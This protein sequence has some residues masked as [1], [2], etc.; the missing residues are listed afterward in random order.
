MGAG[1]RYSFI[2][3]I[4]KEYCDK[5]GWR[6]LEIGAGGAVYK[7]MFM[8]YIGTD[9]AGNP[10]GERGD[11]VAYCD[12]QKIPFKGGS[13]D[14]AFVVAA[15]YQIP[16]ASDVLDEVRRVLRPGGFFLIFDYNEMTTK[17]LKR[18]ERGGENQNQVW[19]PNE[20]KRLATERGFKAVVLNHYRYY[21]PSGSRMLQCM[22]RSRIYHWARNRMREDWNVIVARK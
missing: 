4:L 20:L 15:L 19:S 1:K 11:L 7:D 18:A 10:Y 9:L 14:M 21:P 6:V 8:E 5:P 22:K 2:E 17:R 12:A 16:D 13:F 3:N